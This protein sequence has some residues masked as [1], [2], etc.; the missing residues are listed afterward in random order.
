MFNAPG[1]GSRWGCFDW[2]LLAFVV[3]S[4]LL[5]SDSRPGQRGYNDALMMAG[6][7]LV[8]GSLLFALRRGWIQHL[9]A[10]QN[11]RGQQDHIERKKAEA[12][13]K[14][15][16]STSNGSTADG[17]SVRLLIGKSEHVVSEAQ[18]FR[19][20]VPADTKWSSTQ[21]LGFI[22]AVVERFSRNVPQLSIVARHGSITWEIAVSV[23]IDEAAR[24]RMEAAAQSY[25]PGA[26][27]KLVPRAD[28]V[29]QPYRRYHIF[30]ARYQMDFQQAKS[31]HTIKREDPLASV[32][33]AI[34][35]LREGECLRYTI[36]VL[37]PMRLGQEVIR[38]I[39]TMSAREAGYAPMVGGRNF[40][41]AEHAAGSMIGAAISWTTQ[42]INLG[43]TRLWR[44]PQH[45]TE[46][47]MQKLTQPLLPTN[48]ILQMDTPNEKR[49]SILEDILSSVYSLSSGEEITI[50]RGYTSPTLRIETFEDFFEKTALHYLIDLA[51]KRR[52][53]P[54]ATTPYHFIFTSDELATV[55]HLPHQ[56]MEVEEIHWAAPPPPS[57][58]TAQNTAKRVVIGRVDDLVVS[59]LPQDLRHHAFISGQTGTG[60]SN[61]LHHLVHQFIANGQGCTVLDPHGTLIQRIIEASIQGR[62]THKILL[63][64]LNKEDHPIPLNI[65]RVPEG[66]SSKFAFNMALWVMKAVYKRSWSESQMETT[67][68]NTLE[69]VLTDP[70]ATPQDM[71]RVL[72]NHNYRLMRLQQALRR[73]LSTSAEG[74][75][76][77]QFEAESAHGKR[78]KARSTLNRLRVF[79][80]GTLE[81]MTCHPRGLDF[82]KLIQEG[83]IILVNVSGDDV[84]SDIENLGTILFAQLFLH[85]VSLGLHPDDLPPRHYLVIDETHR[86]ITT[87]LNEMLSTARKYGLSLLMADQWLGQLDEDTRKAIVNNKGTTISF[88]ASEEEAPTVARLY[89]PKVT[90][91]DLIHQD[92]GQAAVKTRFQGKNLSAF[93]LTTFSPL[94]ALPE[95]QRT[96]WDALWQQTVKK[97]DLLPAHEVRQWLRIR[98]KSEAT[99]P[100]D[101]GAVQP[102][103]EAAT[104]V[105]IFESLPTEPDEKG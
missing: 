78:E 40:R 67:V 36:Q 11:L 42:T 48:I 105:E 61:L 3:G 90:V 99:A 1:R 20:L 96:T 56:Y 62:F 10:A 53:E 65:F 77:D 4:V 35:G 64:D 80:D 52:G 19:I 26:V 57:T 41:T 91:D 31:V 93:Q 2:I 92:I 18:H 72:T 66:V 68:R 50:G 86:F 37:P 54:D 85:S 97:L 84:M 9:I 76:K 46:Q 17:T 87:P 98:Y 79:T 101:N 81:L 59:V 28:F 30:Q 49:L 94:S 43:N 58:L 63:L 89:Q 12:E 25:Y 70:E 29:G 8:I 83:Y 27:V 6:F 60:K 5:V 7:W 71:Q 88:A 82:R 55:W 104:D 95:E 21:A 45:E 24:Q 74:W 69:L 38:D 23:D 34:C 100:Q 44:F 47:Y 73:G 39:L 15:L 103:Q 16:R 32:V 14:Q 33:Q 22:R 102:S 51:P 13:E 75:W